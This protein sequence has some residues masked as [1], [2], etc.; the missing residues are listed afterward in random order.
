MPP[1][2]SAETVDKAREALKVLRLER[3]IIGSAV[4]TIYESQSKGVIN[5][6]ERDRM[7]EKYKVDLKRLEKGIEENQHVVDLHDLEAEREEAIKTFNAKLAEIDAKLKK[8]QS[9]APTQKPEK[10][11]SAEGNGKA[12]TQN[13]SKR[14]SDDHSSDSR[15]SDRAPAPSD[16]SDPEK[17]IEQIRED[18]LKAMDRLEQ[19][20]TEG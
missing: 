2:T 1:T 12:Q 20:E 18:I 19:I 4:T 7:L 9:G 13:S 15:S 11:P 5:E 16:T 3:Q 6:A 17:R 8:L 14:S 10:Q